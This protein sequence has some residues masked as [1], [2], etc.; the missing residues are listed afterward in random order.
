[1]YKNQY[2]KNFV[3]ALTTWGIER[4]LLTSTLIL[5][6]CLLLIQ[7]HLWIS[8][9]ILRNYICFIQI[10]GMQVWLP[11]NFKNLTNTNLA[12][13]SSSR[14]RKRRDKAESPWTVQS[15]SCRINSP[16]IHTVES[17]QQMKDYI[18]FS[19]LHFKR[20]KNNVV[21]KCFQQNHKKFTFLMLKQVT[22]NYSV[23]Q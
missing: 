21:Y 11:Q 2:F 3:Y 15:F 19:M 23:I 9:E 17:F 1:M 8:Y 20:Q 14:K 22:I 12:F 10:T 16:Y 5:S 7:L 13:W 4:L 6:A 18:M